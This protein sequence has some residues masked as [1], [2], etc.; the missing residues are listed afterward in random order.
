[1]A[2]GPGVA[3]YYP[4]YVR[5]IF[6]KSMEEME[7]GLDRIEKANEPPRRR[8]TGYLLLSKAT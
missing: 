2:V 5:F 7:G 3:F 8:A 1:M 6:A 4:G